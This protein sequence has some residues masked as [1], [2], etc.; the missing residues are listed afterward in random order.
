MTT[1]YAIIALIICVFGLLVWITRKYKDEGT[2]EANSA[3][4][5]SILKQA[6]D[7]NDVTAKVDAMPDATVDDE[8]RG[9]RK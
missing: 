7:A 8:L 9:W 4:Q 1:Y 5:Q 6:K 3:A 2:M